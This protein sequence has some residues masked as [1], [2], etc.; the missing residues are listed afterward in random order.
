MG[1]VIGIDGGT[2]G[3]RAQIFDLA[4][5]SKASASHAYNTRFAAGARA[6]QDPE[7][8]WRSLGLAVQKAMNGAGIA[9]DAVDALAL[10][11]TCC[12]VVA[13]DD[14]AKPLRPAILWMD[15]RGEAEA[16]ATLAT[17]DPALQVNGAG[18]GPVSAE[19]M[20]PKAL[21]IMGHEPDVFAQATTICEFQDFMNLRL[22]AR[23]CASLNNVTI[24]WHY[25]SERGGYPTTLVEKLR[26]ESLLEKWPTEVLAPGEVIGELTAEAAEH[27]GLRQHVKVIQG[28]ADAFI[29]MPG[30]GVAQPG[31]LALITGSSHLLLGVSHHPMS[32]KGLWGSYPNAVYP[33]RHIIEGGQTSTGSIVNWLKKLAGGDFDLAALNSAAA[34]LE[35][36]CDGLFVLDHFQGNRTPY[37]DASSRGAFIGLTLSHGLPHLFRAVIEG[38][39]FGSKTILDQMAQAGFIV[40][41]MMVGG[42]ATSSDLWLQIHADTTG[43]PVNVPEVSAAPS[44]GAAILAAAGSGH[45]ASIDEGIAHMVRA[46]RIIVP[47]PEN[48]ARYLELFE[49][50][51]ALYPALK[52][53][54]RARS[55]TMPHSGNLQ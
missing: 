8:W 54:N 39:C 15:L 44:L 49:S 36:G 53:F 35:P 22:T 1:Y 14:K 16:A 29:G 12:T 23:R 24:R 26:L 51:A 38:I 27:L 45:F 37:V 9:R 21:W 25:S 5:H 4:G 7:D 2:E 19:W 40:N 41:E 43:L 34:K 30:L 11:T 17:G 46:G 31:Q 3:I 18:K 20:I 50:Y 32:A 28:G 52:P 47:R 6:E 33:G 42:G 10:A 55:S 13:L 48:V